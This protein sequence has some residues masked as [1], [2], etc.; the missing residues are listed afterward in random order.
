MKTF[1]P[2]IVALFVLV[3]AA[4]VRGQVF[5][6]GDLVDHIDTIISEMPST[7]DG[8]SYLQPNLASR[9]LWRQIV[10]DILA[11]EYAAAHEAALTKNY[12][13]VLFT[14]TENG[15]P[16][17]H[18]VLERTPDSTSRYWGTFI[19]NMAPLRP[20]LAIQ[21][22]HPC[23]DSN[24]GY[25]GVRVYAQS[26]ARAYFVSGTHRC[27]G[28][29]YSTCDGTSAVCSGET[30]PYRYSDQAH[31][32]DATF[33][34][35]TEAML[36]VDPELVVLQP[37]GFAQGTGDPDLIISNGT[38]Y[39]P[40]GTDYAVQ[41]R[42]ALLAVDGSLTAKV[43]HVDLSWTELL[44]MTNTQGRLI[45]GSS[46][47]CGTYSTSATGQFVHIEQA[48]IGLRDTP[49]NWQKLVDAVIAAFPD[50][51]SAVP[52]ERLLTGPSVRI[53][54]MYSNPFHGRTRIEFSLVRPGPVEVEVFDLAGRRV[55]RLAVGG[56]D[57]GVHSFDWNAERLPAGTYFLRLRQGDRVDSRRCVLLR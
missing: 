12:Q 54:N 46:D 17:Q 48:R 29:T 18:V 45:N 9:I 49:Q 23:Y 21:C 47:P 50:E 39:T 36:A 10:D 8:G 55:D 2:V 28:L 4:G 41:I 26:A 56:F 52:D 1:N 33:Q 24:T 53:I 13:V 37:H 40:S 5:Q 51:V 44:A 34:I 57:P 25:Q 20:H 16:R 27:N 42:D 32:V 15:D 22:P 3:S 30:E 14:D 6:T 19:F 35:T 7:V 11:G 38:R 43:G 31:V